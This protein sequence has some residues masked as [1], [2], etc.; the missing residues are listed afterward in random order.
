M[1]LSNIRNHEVKTIEL[2]YNEV[3]K[4]AQL[5]C[6]F[7]RIGRGD[8][9]ATEEEMKYIK[10]DI[11]GWTDLWLPNLIESLGYNNNFTSRDISVNH[12]KKTFSITIS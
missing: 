1:V 8:R 10:L 12:F 7:Q 4:F 3:E 11:F 2:D 6:E 5:C 9:F